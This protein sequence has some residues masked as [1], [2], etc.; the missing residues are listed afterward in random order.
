MIYVRNQNCESDRQNVEVLPRTLGHGS[1]DELWVSPSRS[2]IGGVV[3]GGN[4]S[5]LTSEGPM[6]GLF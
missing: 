5:A 1:D 6:T 2:S 3:V 4:T